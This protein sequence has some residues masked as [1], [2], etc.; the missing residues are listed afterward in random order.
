MSDIWERIVEFYKLF[1]KETY[2]YIFFNNI[3]YV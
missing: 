2:N 3:D 1:G